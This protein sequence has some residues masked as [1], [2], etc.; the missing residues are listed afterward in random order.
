MNGKFLEMNA[1]TYES[2]LNDTGRRYM[3]AD[4]RNRTIKNILDRLIEYKPGY[5]WDAH[6]TYAD[7]NGTTILEILIFSKLGQAIQGRISY[8]VESGD[9]NN[10]YYK[11]LQDEKPESVIDLLLDILH[12]EISPGELAN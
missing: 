5:R 9:V 2:S 6:C 8:K 1:K 7:G 11:G 4:E 3:S 10:F 12:V